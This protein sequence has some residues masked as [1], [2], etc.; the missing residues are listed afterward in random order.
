[1]EKPAPLDT[2]AAARQPL[3]NTGFG[4]PDSILLRVGIPRKPGEVFRGQP[5]KL[6]PENGARHRPDRSNP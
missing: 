4:A 5:A 1:M 6:C 2:T 3:G